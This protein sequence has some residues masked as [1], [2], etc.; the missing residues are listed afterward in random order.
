MNERRHQPTGVNHAAEATRLLGTVEH[1]VHDEDTLG[2]AQVRA[3]LAVAH[4]IRDL[5]TAVHVLTGQVGE[6]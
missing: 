5:S 3:I 2:V 1:R 6:P 4:A